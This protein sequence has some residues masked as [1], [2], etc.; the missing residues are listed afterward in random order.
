MLILLLPC[1]LYNRLIFLSMEKG[2]ITEVQD[3]VVYEALGSKSFSCYI[4]NYTA[5][6]K[7]HL[8]DHMI[9]HD[10]ENYEHDHSKR[11]GWNANISN[12]TGACSHCDAS[13]R[14][15][16]ALD[17]HVLKKHPDFISSI[18]SKL[19]ECT[20]CA[21]KTVRKCSLNRH[22]FEHRELY[23]CTK[24]T[25]KTVKKNYFSRHLL[26]H[27]GLASNNR[28]NFFFRMEKIIIS[29]KQR[30]VINGAVDSKSFSCYTCNYTAF[31]KH[32][33]IDHVIVHD[34][35]KYGPDHSKK[36][37]WNANISNKTVKPVAC[38][39]CDASFRDRRTLDD[40][41]LKKHPDFISSITSNHH[42]CT[43]Y[44]FKTVKK[45]SLNRHL[46]EHR[47]VASN[48]KL[49]ICIHCNAT[50][51]SKLS[52]DDHVVRKHPDFISSVTSKL[53]ECTKCT[54]KTVKKS[55]FSRHLLKHPELGSDPKLCI[56]THCN[57]IFSEKGLLDDHVV[58]KHPDFISSVT[59]ELHECTKCDFRTTRKSC[60]S[61]HLLKHPELGSDPKLCICTHCN[62]IFNRKWLLDDHVVRKHPDFISSVTSKLHECTKCTFKTTRKSC[63][64][65]HLL[66]HPEL[67]SDPKLCICIHCNA[68]FTGKRSLDD[69][70]V[71]K[72]PDFISSVTNKLHECTK[73]T[74]KTTIKSC[75]SR[76]LL[77]H[78][79]LGSDPKLCICIHCNAKFNGKWLLDDHVVRKHPDFIS[80]ITS[81]LHECTKC[82]FK[83]TLKSRFSKHLLK[84]PEL[85]SDFK[86]KACNHCNAT[87]KSKISL[88][89]H[90][91]REHPNFISSVTSKLHE[92]TKCTFKTTQKNR[93]S[94]HLQKHPE[95]PSD[96][97]LKACNTTFKGKWLLDD[98]V[99]RKHPDFIS[100]V[101]SKLYECTKCTFKTTRKS[102]FS[103]HLQKHPELASDFKLNICIHCNATF[104]SK[105]SLDDHLVKKHPDF[106]KT[107][108][109]KITN[110][111][112]ALT[113]YTCKHYNAVFVQ[114]HIYLYM[115]YIRCS[116]KNRFLLTVTFMSSLRNVDLVASYNL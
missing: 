73:C 90:V 31:S 109:T 56:C 64:S 83:T 2:I 92:C 18:T 103:K 86:L 34:N 94:K 11:E 110:V 10:N 3:Q 88:D 1:S 35:E 58:K 44:A 75:F 51:T 115:L 50:F 9:V 20:K 19:H 52:L 45:C 27:P 42:E 41:V 65:R 112:N 38:S 55:C 111:Q 102:R 77:K 66:K 106:I 69:H 21:F 43:K 91:V 71:R 46:L 104:K 70:V 37:G 17:D 89:G 16:R 53:H 4:C 82:I 23:E 76:H 6:S 8:I 61:R 14:D 74:F 78:P 13:F 62:A 107:V 40:H 68:K 28:L 93:F 29:M 49:K 5:F 101:T 85:P 95:L 116:W 26:K 63:F 25:F 87:F 39:H 22:L 30:Q 99:V 7:H 79:G 114:K 32:H 48:A 100:S 72:H 80:S 105:K 67:G 97:K 54:F 113:R 59:S 57:A 60:F 36:D 15:K 47:E 108:T 81:K 33:L 12:K 84:H 24:C 98:H 96:F